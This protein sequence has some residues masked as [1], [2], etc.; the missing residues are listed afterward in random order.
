MNDFSPRQ[1]WENKILVWEKSRYA[2]TFFFNPFSWT[3]RNRLKTSAAFLKDMVKADWSVVE[4]G[5][6]SGY[7]AEKLAPLVRQYTGYDIAHNAIVHAQ[8]RLK[9]PN[10]QFATL[11]VQQLSVLNPDLVLF[12]GLTDW[13]NDQEMQHLF[14][15]LDSRHLFFSYTEKRSVSP[16]NP[17]FYYRR[18]MDYSSTGA[19]Y[20]A[21]HFS[22]EDI[23]QLLKARGYKATFMR[24]SIPFDPG[25][26]VVAHR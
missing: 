15:S 14:S 24:S 4:V 8:E 23:R 19:G 20:K 2:Q 18:L 25:V 22:E 12:L 17:Y 9:L 1:F 26:L 7:L 3:I 16:F 11:P 21:R 5:C 10:V 6:G 13:L